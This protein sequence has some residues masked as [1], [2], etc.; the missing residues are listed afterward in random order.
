MGS[1]ER[2]IRE[3]EEQF[4]RPALGEWEADPE[5]AYLEATGEPRP[6]VFGRYEAAVEGFRAALEEAKAAKAPGASPVPNTPELTAAHGE[7][8]RARN[9]L[10]AFSRERGEAIG[11][12]RRGGS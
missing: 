2:R 5:R 3:L 12:E 4:S 11:S 8:L 1:I 6:A 9:E 10:R 7:M